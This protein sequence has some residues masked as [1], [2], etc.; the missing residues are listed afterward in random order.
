M[1]L[2]KPV[3]YY[4]NGWYN[5]SI[6]SSAFVEDAS[7]LKLRTL[8]LTYDFSDAVLSKVGLN[9]LG[10]DGVEVGIIGRNIFTVDNYSGFDPEVVSNNRLT[11]LDNYVYPNLRNYT[12][13]VGVTF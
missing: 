4:V 6:I 5:G 9:G 12:F 3:S 11:P 2:R 7:F 1:E 8:S 13:T 10:A